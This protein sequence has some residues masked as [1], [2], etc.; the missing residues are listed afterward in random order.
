MLGDA[1]EIVFD[2]GIW[3]AIE[4]VASDVTTFIEANISSVS[5]YTGVRPITVGW[6]ENSNS[7]CVFY[8]S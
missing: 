2:I 4:S 8:T 5:S 7:G 6:K 1:V 3:T